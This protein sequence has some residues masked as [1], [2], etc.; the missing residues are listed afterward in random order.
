MSRLVRF[1]GLWTVASALVV[2]GIPTAASAKDGFRAL[3]TEDFAFYGCSVPVNP[4]VFDLCGTATTNRGDASLTTVITSF[5]PLPSGCFADSH[6][7]VLTFRGE[8]HDTVSFDISGTLCPTGGPNFSFS[9]KYKVA[10]GTGEY[11][12][13]RG[14]GDVIGARQNGPIHTQLTGTLDD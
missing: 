2:L 12:K 5:A 6:T 3:L 7:T 14:S 13:A 1:V 11:R 10:G 4:T 8:H 9:G